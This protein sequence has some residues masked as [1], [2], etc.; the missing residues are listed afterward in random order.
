MYLLL[1]NL[2]KP[3][4]IR[5][6]KASFKVCRQASGITVVVLDFA[7]WFM[8]VVMSWRP[9]AACFSWLILPMTSCALR[10]SSGLRLKCRIRKEMIQD[11]FKW[12][13]W[14]E[15][16]ITHISEYFTL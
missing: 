3:L 7:S 5:Q 4:Q 13:I 15:Q 6:L 2:H 12:C 11:A 16:M 14:Y 8:V 1:H 10:L 9:S